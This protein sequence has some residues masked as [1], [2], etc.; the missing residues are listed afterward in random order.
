MEYFVN[1]PGSFTAR[2]PISKSNSLDYQA[3]GTCFSPAQLSNLGFTNVHILKLIFEFEKMLKVVF[4][5]MPFV[6][7]VHMC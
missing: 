7:V 5:G 1:I 2:S 4:L 6:V 3:H